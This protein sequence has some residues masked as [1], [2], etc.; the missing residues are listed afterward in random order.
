[1]LSQGRRGFVW[2][3]SRLMKGAEMDEVGHAK[4]V[5][6]QFRIRDLRAVSRLNHGP[7]RTAGDP[8]FGS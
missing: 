3:D 8:R 6:E 1:M 5:V 2:H 4:S 7:R